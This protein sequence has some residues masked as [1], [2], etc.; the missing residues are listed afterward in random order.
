M[1]D[2]HSN[3]NGLAADVSSGI[4][5]GSFA[6]LRTARLHSW[7]SKLKDEV[8]KGRVSARIEKLKFGHLGDYKIIGRDLLELRDHYGPGYRVYVLRQQGAFIALCGGGKGG[9]DRDI[10]R[11][12]RLA[13]SLRAPNE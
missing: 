5:D 11:A 6:V 12:R 9:Q 7:L 3:T 13:S 10:Q 1:A 4:Q 8:G 2:T